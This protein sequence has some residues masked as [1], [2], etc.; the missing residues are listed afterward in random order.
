MPTPPSTKTA[1]RHMPCTALPSGVTLGRSCVGQLS[2]SSF[3]HAS[4]SAW[5]GFD[6]NLLVASFS[7]FANLRCLCLGR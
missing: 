4:T 5:D 2:P 1:P 6:D 7:A 3:R